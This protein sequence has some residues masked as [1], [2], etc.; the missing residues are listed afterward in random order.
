MP[1]A[2]PMRD[3]AGRD[4]E[5]GVQIERTMRVFALRAY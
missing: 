1:G 5:G 4:F 2:E 3:V